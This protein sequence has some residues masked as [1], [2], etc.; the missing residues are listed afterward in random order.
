MFTGLLGATALVTITDPLYY[1]WLAPKRW[2]YLALQWPFHWLIVRR[3][4]ARMAAHCSE[5]AR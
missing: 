3:S 2:L 5:A 4:L 1:K